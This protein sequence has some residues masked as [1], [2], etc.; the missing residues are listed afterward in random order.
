LIPYEEIQSAIPT[1]I[2]RLDKPN[3][4]DA[5]KFEFQGVIPFTITVTWPVDEIGVSI[6]RVNNYQSEL[7]TPD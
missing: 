3:Y 5:I 7:A 4:E 2:S 6:A 1:E